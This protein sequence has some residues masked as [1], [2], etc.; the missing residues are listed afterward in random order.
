MVGLATNVDFSVWYF[1]LPFHCLDQGLLESFLLINICFFST[2][3][4]LVDLIQVKFFKFLVLLFSFKSE[5][6]FF[7]VFTKFDVAKV[8]LIIKP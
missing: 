7:E 1:I 5:L 6:V 2:F 8:I 3:V 4:H